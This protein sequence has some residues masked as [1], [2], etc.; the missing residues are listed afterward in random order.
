MTDK[1]ERF[2]QEYLK[3]ANATQAAIRA[4]YS[5][6]TANEQGA[7]MLAKVSIKERLKELRSELNVEDTISRERIIAEYAKIAFFNPKNAYTEENLVKN[8]HDLSDEDAA[9]IS[10]IKSFESFGPDGQL[11]GYNKELKFHDKL[12]ALEA[13]GKIIGIFERDN[14]Q[15]KGE[16]NMGALSDDVIKALIDASR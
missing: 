1:Q 2:C 4:G 5:E 3:D 15:K 12:R 13:L 6:K 8:I 11:L 14:R 16:V 10:Q 9:V 7:R